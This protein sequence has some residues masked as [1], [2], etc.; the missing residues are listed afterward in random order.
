M[1]ITS[2]DVALIAYFGPLEQLTGKTVYIL[3]SFFIACI[4]RIPE[5]R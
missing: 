3:V 1:V 5:P 2:R 4:R